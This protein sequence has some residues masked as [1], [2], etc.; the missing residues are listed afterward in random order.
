MFDN[1]TSIEKYIKNVKETLKNKDLL[2]YTDTLI[3]V[4]LF[5]VQNIIKNIDFLINKLND[6]PK[7]PPYNNPAINKTITD[8]NSYRDFYSYL[9]ENLNRILQEKDIVT[10][11]TNFEQFITDQYIYLLS[12]KTSPNPV[13]VSEDIYILVLLH[14]D[15]TNIILLNPHISGNTSLKTQIIGIDKKFI[16]FIENAANNGLPLFTSEPNDLM[17]FYE[18]ILKHS[19][20]RSEEHSLKD[21][22]TKFYFDPNPGE[23]QNSFDC[24]YGLNIFALMLNLYPPSKNIDLFLPKE[25]YST[26]ETHKRKLNDSTNEG[27]SGKE[28]LDTPEWR[29]HRL[30]IEKYKILDK[31]VEIF[32][33][34]FF[35]GLNYSNPLFEFINYTLENNI[36]LIKTYLSEQ[37]ENKEFKEKEFKSYKYGV[38]KL[39]NSRA[40]KNS[41]GYPLSDLQ[42]IDKYINELKKIPKTDP[43][44][45]TY[46]RVLEFN[47][48]L[49]RMLVGHSGK[50]IIGS[51]VKTLKTALLSDLIYLFRYLLNFDYTIFFLPSCRAC[52]EGQVPKIGTDRRS[53]GNTFKQRKYKKSK[54]NK[55][56]TY[57]RK[58]NKRKTYKRKR[59]N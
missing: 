33:Q 26:R 6:I 2:R 25:K 53:G 38:E 45:I 42:I 52:Q 12:W 51:Y 5:N 48:I 32:K 41:Q 44:L 18:G 50:N 28:Q 21:E 16:R 36:L 13:N 34:R 40:F 7:I 54:T 59:L 8:F 22:D 43:L 56:K 57:K 46:C 1:K 58:T 27:L 14:N 37:I 3:Q 20:W 49:T 24:S 4:Y 9:L 23:G 10:K 35:V 30:Q 17:V 55:R 31:I 11:I 15:I 39:K 29:Y 47:D 19:F